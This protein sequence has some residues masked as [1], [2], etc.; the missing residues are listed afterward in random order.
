MTCLSSRARSRTPQP[1]PSSAPSLSNANGSESARCGLRS[2]PSTLHHPPWSLDD[3]RQRLHRGEGDGGGARLAN[4]NGAIREPRLA[5]G[6]D[7]R[8]ARRYSL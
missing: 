6:R 4:G 2:S 1:Q 3:G 8:G 7:G 5:F